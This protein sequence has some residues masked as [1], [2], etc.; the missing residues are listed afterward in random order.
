MLYAAWCTGLFP[1]R[2]RELEDPKLF[3]RARRELE[4]EEPV[5]VR[6]A[7]E[8]IRNLYVAG[9][10]ARRAMRQWR[11]ATHAM[12]LAERENVWLCLQQVLSDFTR[13]SDQIGKDNGYVESESADSD[14]GASPQGS[15]TA[16]LHTSNGA[17]QRPRPNK[18]SDRGGLSAVFERSVADARLKRP[19]GQRSCVPHSSGFAEAR[20]AN[21]GREKEPATERHSG[22][23]GP[24]PAIPVRVVPLWKLH[25][26]QDRA[27]LS[28]SSVPP[29][30]R[31]TIC[32]M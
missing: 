24:A 25:S 29:C 21:G 12:D 15:G 8:L 18:R 11:E 1:I 9:A 30:C 13:L 26:G 23:R 3:L 7:E 19:N 17:A 4:E 32:S 28:G 2:Q 16:V 10:I 6:A 14:P 22:R 31:A 20:S 27:T 5:A